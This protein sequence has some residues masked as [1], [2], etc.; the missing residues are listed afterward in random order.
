MC[1]KAYGMVESTTSIIMGE[2]FST[3]KKHLK[4]LVI[5]KLIKDKIKEIVASFESLHGIPYI[6]HAING[7]HILIV[8]P[9]VH[10]KSY[11][12]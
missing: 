4:P 11:Y 10:S 3:I 6:L 5:P 2:L 9:K 8:V 12:Y 1:G 7:S